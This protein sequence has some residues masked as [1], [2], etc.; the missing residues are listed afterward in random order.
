LHSGWDFVYGKFYGPSYSSR[1]ANGNNANQIPCENYNN[2]NYN[3]YTNHNS[4]PQQ[5]VKLDDKLD[6]RFLD[7]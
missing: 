4:Q 2:K 1:D 6:Q 3:N 7:D 5:Y